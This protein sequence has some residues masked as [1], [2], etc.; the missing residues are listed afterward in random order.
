MKRNPKQPP[1]PIKINTHRA[2]TELSKLLRQVEET[3]ATYMI[4]RNGKV[5]AELRPVSQQAEKTPL[6]PDPQLK[7]LSYSA[8]AFQSTSNEDWPEDMR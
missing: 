6:I 4:C 1:S 7:R 3:Q 2:K 5:I 8:D